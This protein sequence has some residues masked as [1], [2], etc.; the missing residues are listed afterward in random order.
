[1]RREP[2]LSPQPSG[3]AAH[4]HPSFRRDLRRMKRCVASPELPMSNLAASKPDAKFVSAVFACILAG[5][6]IAT[7]LHRADAAESCITEPK[8]KT[9]QGMHWYY[10]IDHANKRQCWYLRAEG[11]AS[12]AAS[13]DSSSAPKVTTSA[14]K[15]TSRKGETTTQGSI[16]DARAELPMPQSSADPGAGV[17]AA[18][19]TQ[20]I[21]PDA[22]SAVNDS[23]ANAAGSTSGQSAVASRWPESAGVSSTAD[24]QPAESIQEADASDTPAAA[25]SPAAAPRSA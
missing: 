22:A 9:P 23:R 7:I 10:R 18:S 3:I 17:P 11:A 13:A 4:C 19:P 2:K 20:T 12:Q 24:P 16:A 25:P 5:A 14:P 21:W 8:E 15:M 1:M 6:A